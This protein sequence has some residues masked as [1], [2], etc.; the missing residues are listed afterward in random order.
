[1]VWLAR[2]AGLAPSSRFSPKNPF[3]ACSGTVC[4]NETAGVALELD[5]YVANCVLMAPELPPLW[6]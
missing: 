5:Q 6:L 2:L 1:M 4:F 3:H